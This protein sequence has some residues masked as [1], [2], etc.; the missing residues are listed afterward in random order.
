[1]AAVAPAIRTDR[2]IV[3]RGVDLALVIGSALA[4]YPTLL[5]AVFHVPISLLWW[6]WSVGFD[7]THIFGTASRRFSIARRARNPRCSSAAC[8]FL[9][10]G[11]RW[12]C[13]E[14]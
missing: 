14:R 8:L 13:W 2:W 10:L 11:R 7:G 6:F 4:G 9:A 12:C 3:G 1:M 5:C